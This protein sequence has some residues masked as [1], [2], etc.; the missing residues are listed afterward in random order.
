ML[1]LAGLLQICT[2]FKTDVLDLHPVQWIFQGGVSKR[3]HVLGVVWSSQNIQ[4]HLGDKGAVGSILQ[5]VGTT[6]TDLHPI[7]VGIC[8]WEWGI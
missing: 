3:S 6:T 4:E 5:S 7:N 1:N 2:Y 8:I